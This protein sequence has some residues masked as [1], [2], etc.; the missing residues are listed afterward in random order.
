M[1]F[2][3]MHVLAVFGLQ[4]LFS[5]ATVTMPIML[6]STTTLYMLSIQNEAQM[7]MSFT[8]EVTHVICKH[9]DCHPITIQAVV[10]VV[11]TVGQN[12]LFFCQQS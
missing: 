10:V 1:N 3:F 12:A 4:A 11:T 5:I 7:H 8:A 6:L 2:Q 9:S